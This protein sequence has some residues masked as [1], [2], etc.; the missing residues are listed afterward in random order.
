MERAVRN[1]ATLDADNHLSDEARIMNGPWDIEVRREPPGS[2]NE[3]G[4]QNAN[5]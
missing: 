4:Q 5:V 3:A 2:V 1:T